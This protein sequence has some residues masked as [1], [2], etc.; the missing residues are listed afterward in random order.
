[1]LNAVD[2]SL[3]LVLDPE[4]CGGPAAM[5]RTA[6]S[7]AENGA[8]VVQLRAPD[9][10][11][12]QW[13]E[14]ARELKAALAPFGVPLIVNDSLEAA[15]TSDA[16][17]LHVGQADGDVREIRVRLGPGKILG[18][19]TQ[20]VAQARAAEADGADYL[21]VGAVFPTATKPDAAEIPLSELAAICAAVRIPVV[22]IGGIH[23]G[24][25]RALS[26]TGIAGLC[27]V[28]A[29]FARPDRVR[30]AARELRALSAKI[31]R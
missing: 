24:N 1:M 22:A 8:T 26:G 14:T 7:A 18:V 21:G 23:A 11:K 31:C 6:R 12:R 20:T 3:Y 17:G 13:L 5:V 19:S 15:I 28:S 30:D 29:L 16:A 9:W 25:A 4:L 27:V 10:K 2:L